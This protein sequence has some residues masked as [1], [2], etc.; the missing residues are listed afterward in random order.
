MEQI[1][2]PEYKLIRQKRKTLVLRIQDDNS[3]E[4]RAPLRTSQRVIDDFVYRHLK[5]IDKTKARLSKHSSSDLGE[6]E[7][8]NLKRDALLY[9]TERTKHYSEIMNLYPTSIKITSARTRF[10]SCSYKNSLC[11][12]YRLMLYP[13]EARDYV[14][15]HELAHIKHKNHGTDFYKTIEKYLPDYKERKKLLK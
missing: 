3:I 6:D 12:S 14:V 5:W 2:L 1:N 15:V 4:V 10:G 13:K 7:I 11:F 8:R 9:L